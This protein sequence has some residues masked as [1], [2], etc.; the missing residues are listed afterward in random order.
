MTTRD[1]LSIA[2]GPDYPKGVSIAECPSKR[3]LECT[4][5]MVKWPGSPKMCWLCHTL[6][7][8]VLA[9]KAKCNARWRKYADLPIDQFMAG[10]PF[11]EMRR[12]KLQLVLKILG[13]AKKPITTMTLQARME[14]GGLT[15]SQSVLREYLSDLEMAGFVEGNK[16][17][18]SPWVF[19]IARAYK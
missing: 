12:S 1:D 7:P 17:R 16:H 3:H 5:V 4:G 19:G 10:Y 6:A 9:A 11:G 2:L 14:L 18:T 8:K 15:P 13:E